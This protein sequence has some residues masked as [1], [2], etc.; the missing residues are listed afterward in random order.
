MLE[1][2]YETRRVLPRHLRPDGA[3]PSPNSSTTIRPA[4]RD[5]DLP[6][7]REIYNHYVLNSSIT[8]DEKPHDASLAL[9]KKFA[10]GERLRMPFLVAESPRGEILGIAWVYPWQGNTSQRRS[11]ELSIYLGPAATGKGLGKVLLERLLADRR[12]PE[13]G[14]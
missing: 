12:M 4:R 8:F 13:S 5:A 2:E 7:V 3:A 1:E 10:T 14:K 11:V 9:R 6:S